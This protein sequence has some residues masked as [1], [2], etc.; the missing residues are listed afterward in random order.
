MYCSK[1][2]RN[3][4]ISKSGKIKVKK[5]Q[6]FKE[7]YHSK[8]FKKL[9]LLPWKNKSPLVNQLNPSKEKKNQESEV[10]SRC[11]WRRLQVATSILEI[12]QIVIKMATSSSG[13]SAGSSSGSLVH[14]RKEEA[15]PMTK[16]EK[17]QYGCF[18]TMVILLWVSILGI[19]LWSLDLVRQSIKIVKDAP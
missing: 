18:V 8:A 9:W 5:N 2:C 17:L 15:P 13:S 7:T 16:K 4:H 14:Y 10:F 12:G 11:W 19:S 1:L 6:T 3:P